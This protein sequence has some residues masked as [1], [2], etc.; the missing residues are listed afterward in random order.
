VATLLEIVVDRRDGDSGNGRLRLQLGA[1]LDVFIAGLRRWR[2]A[3][4]DLARRFI[5]NSRGTGGTAGVGYLTD[6]LDKG[7]RPS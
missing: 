3:H 6:R 5:A 7:S 2:V 4:R 1:Q